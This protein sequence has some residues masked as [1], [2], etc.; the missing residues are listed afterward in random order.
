MVTKC[1][2]LG[3]LQAMRDSEVR[4]CVDAIKESPTNESSWRYLRGLFKGDQTAFTENPLVSDVCVT[5]LMKDPSNVLALSFLLDL[6]CA[7]FQPTSSC[8]ETLRDILPCWSTPS[9]LATSV[10][11]C[12]QSLDA[13]RTQ[14]WAWRKSLLPLTAP[15]FQS[16]DA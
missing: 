4:Y 2:T 6:L 5:E 7:G 3:G 8:R 16:M 1:P 14:Y 12:L 13:I 10:C 11:S 9:E 15:L